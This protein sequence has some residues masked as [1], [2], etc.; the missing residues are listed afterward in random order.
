FCSGRPKNH[1]RSSW[2]LNRAGN[3]DHCYSLVGVPTP[4]NLTLWWEP[5]RNTLFLEYKTQDASQHLNPFLNALTAAGFA[6]SGVTVSS[7]LLKDCPCSIM[8]RSSCKADGNPVPL[9]QTC[10]GAQL[11][12]SHGV[13]F[14]CRDKAY[15][16][17]PPFW[18]GTCSLGYVTPHLDLAWSNISLPL[19]VY[20][21]QRICRAVILTPLFLALGLT[22][23][24]A[25]AAMGRTS[26]HKFQQ[27]S[28]DTAVSIEK[29]VR[30]LQCLQSQLDSLA[31]MVLQNR[32]ALDLLT[33][34]QGGTCLY[35]KEE[36]CFYYNQT[37][38]VQEDIKGLLEQA[39]KI[40][41]LSSTSV[42]SSLSFPSWLLPFMGPV[43]T[44]LLGLLFGPCILQLLTKFISS[45]LQQFQAK[46]MLLQG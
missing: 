5:K 29:T 42:W 6:A 16:S 2:F 40:R 39:T 33:A 21:N 11:K 3:S 31:A 38:Q 1:I 35:L 25:G 44:I 34:G 19:L 41:D 46:L 7:Q 15:L 9:W 10:F 27:L 26:L 37:G 36:C 43:V 28:T 8:P 18:S 30:T 14:T 13:Y 22:A 45:R 32:R 17:L 20:T 23:G 24:L 4:E 12:P